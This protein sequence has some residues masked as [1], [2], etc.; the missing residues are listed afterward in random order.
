MKDMT[1]GSISWNIISLALPMMLA[2]LLHT[3]FNI[4][5]TIFVGRIS[6]L[7]LAAISITFPVIFL[8]IALASGVGIGVTSLIA[9]LLG[10]KRK[11][12]ANNAAEH[13]LLLA[14]ILGIIF[15]IAGLTLS[16]PL[17][18]LIGATEEMMPLILKYVYIIFGGSFFMFFAFMANSI[19]RGEGDMKTPMKIMMLS[20]VI[21]IILDP[22]L[23]FGIGFF[24]KMGIGGAAL[25]T[26]IARSI[27]AFYAMGYLLKGN[28]HIKLDFKHFKFRFKIIKDILSV[29]VPAS[30]SQTVMSLGMFFMMKIVSLFGPFAIAAYGLASRLDMI[31][32]LPA[33]GISTA[34]ITIVG[35]NVGAK[36]F[37]RAEKTTWTATLMAIIFMEVIGIILFLFPEFWI[38]MF[39]K[40]SEII[41]YGSS[42]IRIVSLLYML[43]GVGIII[44]SAF[45]GAG[46]GYPS[47]ILSVLRL[48]ILS[49]P[50][51]YFLSK[52]Y[53]VVGIWLG[54]A[55]SIIVT[56][57]VAAIWFKMG[58]WKKGK[59]MPI[60]DV[61]VA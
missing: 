12:E 41:A 4:V 22:L 45:Q 23:I 19:L 54:I 42:Y 38:S 15:T 31:A 18:I 13:A 11:E 29:G 14:V 58:T 49:V 28:A 30:L 16:K 56:A 55:V 43:I 47:L 2:F 20:T 25:A 34:V 3:G 21:N 6:A 10:S 26:V 57:V 59:H 46:K 39:N 24:P 1:K 48:F 44:S 36:N 50:L 7:A 53:G 51:A 9:R 33:I 61:P 17:F 60:K 5:D 32:L 37:K 52:I 35:Q 8:I 40:N 27:A